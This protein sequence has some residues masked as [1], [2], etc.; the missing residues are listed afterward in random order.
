MGYR[1]MPDCEIRFRGGRRDRLGKKGFDGDGEVR[2]GRVLIGF[3]AANRMASAV[4]QKLG[5]IPMEIATSRCSAG[6]RQEVYEGDGM[7][8]GKLSWSRDG[9]A[10][11]LPGVPGG[12]SSRIGQLLMAKV[13]G[14][15]AEN[16]QSAVGIGL[17][18]LRQGWKLRGEDRLTGKV[19]DEQHL[20]AIR[21]QW[22]Q[23]AI[24]QN[25]R[26]VPCCEPGIRCMSGRRT[27]GGR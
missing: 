8:A 7:D 10:E 19:D 15:Y 13:C 22:L 12:N 17:L 26:K 5:V 3:K 18:E 14:G 4:N 9:E 21:C 24:R 23:L 11:I 2:T 6:V 27:A 16:D 25:E 20:A 1:R